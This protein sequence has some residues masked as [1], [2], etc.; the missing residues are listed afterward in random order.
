[1]DEKEELK[2]LELS[3]INMMSRDYKVRF[4]AE[5]VQLKIRADKLERML[6]AWDEGRLSFTPTNPKR[7]LQR[8]LR[9]MREY[10]EILETRARIEDIVLPLQE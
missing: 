6:Y 2:Q 8:Q 9:V 10:E 1:M 5:Y 7:L 4:V 3:S